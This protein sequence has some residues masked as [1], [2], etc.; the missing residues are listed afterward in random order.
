MNYNEIVVSCLGSGVLSGWEF[1][2]FGEDAL[3][4]SDILC[5]LILGEIA[6]VNC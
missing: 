6:T 5:P 3:H 1:T 4:C 2:R